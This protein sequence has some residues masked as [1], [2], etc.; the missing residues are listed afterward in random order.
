MD[1][2]CSVFNP[3]VLVFKSKQNVNTKHRTIPF[4][5]LYNSWRN[6]FILPGKI[7][8]NFLD[9]ELR[10]LE[11]KECLLVVINIIICS[12]AAKAA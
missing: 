3:Y 4:I 5:Q 7:Q 11:A 9:T 2:K 10:N 8:R 12:T 6:L 1:L